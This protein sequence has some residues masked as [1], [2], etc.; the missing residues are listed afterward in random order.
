MSFKNT[1]IIMTRCAPHAHSPD[2][3]QLPCLLC[4]PRYVSSH[5]PCSVFGLDRAS[6]RWRWDNLWLYDLHFHFAVTWGQQPFWRWAA[7]SQS[8]SRTWSWTRCAYPLGFVQMYMHMSGRCEGA[9]LAWLACWYT[10][11]LES[12]GSCSLRCML[13]VRSH[14]RPEFVNRID[15][16]IVFQVDAVVSGWPSRT[17]VL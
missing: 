3:F 14:F 8:A 2:H 10:D 7:R 16:F 4:L 11:T 17:S 9:V 5:H 13:Q 6:D 15:E 1:I 12:R